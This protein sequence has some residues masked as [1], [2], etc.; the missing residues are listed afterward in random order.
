MKRP[1]FVDDHAQC[2]GCGEV[3]K[4]KHVSIPMPDMSNSFWVRPPRG[5][6]VT[7]ATIAVGGEVGREGEEKTV[8]LDKP[9]QIAIFTCE[10]CIELG[11]VSRGEQVAGVG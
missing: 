5:W 10:R 8:T 9:V 11:R 7:F 6:F 4:L 3:G 1:N 2:N